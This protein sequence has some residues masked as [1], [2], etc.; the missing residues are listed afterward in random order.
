MQRTFDV[1]AVRGQLRAPE[2]K[3]NGRRAVHLDGPGGF[4]VEKLAIEAVSG[5]MSRSGAN[6]MALSRR[7]SKPK[8]SCATPAR[9]QRL[10][11]SRTRRGCLRRQQAPRTV[12]ISRAR[13]HARLRFPRSWWT[14]LD[15]RANVDPWL[16]AAEKGATVR[17][18]S[19][20]PE[21]LTRDPHSGA[22]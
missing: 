20:N 3:H 7:P 5:Y 13:A 21:T 2:R 16:L 18:I 22:A 17:W 1:M 12:A 14:E 10:P 15:H 11:R 4:Q 8:R 6:L 9:P 19:A